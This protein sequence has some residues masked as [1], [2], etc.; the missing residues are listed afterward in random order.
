MFK[1]KQLCIFPGYIYHAIHSCFQL[2]DILSENGICILSLYP[3]CFFIVLVAYIY[4]NFL[5]ININLLFYSSSSDIYTAYGNP[6][7]IYH[8]LNGSL[9]SNSMLDSSSAHP[10]A[11]FS[12]LGFIS[13]FPDDPTKSHKSSAHHI[14]LQHSIQVGGYMGSNILKSG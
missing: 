13:F 14:P 7:I 8:S 5:R 1:L 6:A 11:F 9:S 2:L 10:M 4:C 3:V 12:S